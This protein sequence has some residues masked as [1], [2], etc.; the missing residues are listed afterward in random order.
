M[1][2]LFT[3]IG[4]HAAGWDL[5]FTHTHTHTHTPKLQSSTH[6]LWYG[7]PSLPKHADSLTGEKGG[8]PDRKGEKREKNRAEE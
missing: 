6:F 2:P 4:P 3:P 7:A 5:S 8:D 1:T